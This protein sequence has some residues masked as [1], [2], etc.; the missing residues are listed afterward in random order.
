M[1]PVALRCP[2]STTGLWVRT[3]GGVLRAPKAGGQ[4]GMYAAVAAVLRAPYFFVAM[5]HRQQYAI[6][7]PD[8]IKIEMTDH[9]AVEVLPQ[10]V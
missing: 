7:R 5:T 3:L 8:R 4:R 10:P 1:V 6:G 2:V 9:A